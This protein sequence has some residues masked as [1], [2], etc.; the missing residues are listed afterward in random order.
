MVSIL[1]IV[2]VE[3]YMPKNQRGKYQKW[4]SRRTIKLI[5]GST[6]ESNPPGRFL[7]PLTGFE[8]RAAHQRLKY[9]RDIKDMKLQKDSSN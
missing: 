8:D 5:G 9:F 7:I 6:W 3:N 4:G 1:E 2:R